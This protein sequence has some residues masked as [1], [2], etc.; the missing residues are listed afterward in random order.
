MRFLYILSGWEGS[1]ADATLF[2]DARVNDLTVPVGKYYLADAGFGS[3][4]AAL[5]PYRGERYHLAETGRAG[6]R[7]ILLSMMLHRIKIFNRPANP[8][9][10]FNLRHAQLRN[11]VERIF[12]V[13]KGKW[14]ILTRP[15]E[16]DIDIQARIPPALAALHNFILKHDSIEWEDILEMDVE[17]PAPGMC[18][19]ADNDFGVLA[20]GA[21]TAQEKRRSEA[22]WDAIAKAIWDSYQQVL[23]ERGEEP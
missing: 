23:R 21:T 7:Y 18:R 20:H 1:T 15:P 6:V 16:Y 10:L 4:D 8:R 2:L 13:L 9:E 22:R 14:G 12:G 5:V 11:V 17:D 19:G 3:C